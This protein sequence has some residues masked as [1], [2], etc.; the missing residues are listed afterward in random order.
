MRLRP[1]MCACAL[2]LA[3]SSPRAARADGYGDGLRALNDLVN[4]AIG[5]ALVADLALL[6]Y[7]VVE[8]ARG[9]MP[10]RALS[11]TEIVV[12]APQAAL[13]VTAGWWAKDPQARAPWLAASAFTMTL[14]VHGVWGALAPGPAASGPGTARSG[15][16]IGM[17]GS[18]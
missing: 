4:V 15:L 13:A 12:A 3:I 16:G 7:D 10:S 18:F 14:T 9:E 8:A 6:T 1:A 5:V 17:A 2:A 11:I